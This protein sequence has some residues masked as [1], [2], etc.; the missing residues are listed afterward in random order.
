MTSALRRA[1]V[2]AIVA[3]LALATLASPGAFAQTQDDYQVLVVG[4]TLGFRHS[5][6]DEATQAIIE[7][8]EDNGFT[9]DVWDPPHTIGQGSP[10]QPDL[11]LA[12]TPFTTAQNLAQY[13]TIIFLSPVDNTNNLDPNRPRLLDDTELA[14]LQGYVRNGGGV[15]GI[16]AATDTMHTS[17]W[18]TQLIGGGARFRNHPAQQNAVVVVEDPTHPSTEMLPQRWQRFDEWYNFTQQPEDVHVLLTLDESTYNAGSG[19]MG[20]YHP[21]SWCQNFEG[22][23]SW[24]EGGGHTE[25]SFQEPLFLEHILAGIEWTAGITSGG[26]NCVTF[27]EVDDLVGELDTS[28]PGRAAAGARILERF[29][30]RAEAAADEGDRT[31]ALRELRH[32]ATIA[33]VLLRDDE[34]SGKIA[35]LTEWQRGLP[36]NPQ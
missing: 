16:H 30:D 36:D 15:V 3:T 14:A 21:I 4:E 19:A 5:N 1:L 8:G 6:I 11:T 23:R 10:G 17:S 28:R 31:R 24:Y 13:A 9:V 34:L 33:R 32:A 25:A 26:G 27:G 2:G 18:F 29:L 12:S 22:G 35:D 7:L 20:D